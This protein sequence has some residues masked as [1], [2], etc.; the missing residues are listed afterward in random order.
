MHQAMISVT[1]VKILLAKTNWCFHAKIQLFT[2]KTIH[3]LRPTCHSTCP[4]SPRILFSKRPS[5]LYESLAAGGKPST[6]FP[7]GGLVETAAAPSNIERQTTIP[8]HNHTTHR[9][10]PEEMKDRMVDN[11]FADAP[12]PP[13][14]Y[15][16]LSLCLVP[17]LCIT[18]HLQRAVNRQPSY[19][20][21]D[22]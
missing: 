14:I 17:S 8:Q 2:R 16:S 4:L 7:P 9:V 20:P 10:A 6:W 11:S 18:H 13:P 19:R 1:G 3:M 22:S 15:N 21:G 5:R 12:P